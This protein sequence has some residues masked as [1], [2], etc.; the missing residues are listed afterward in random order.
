MLTELTCSGQYGIIRPVVRNATLVL[1]IALLLAGLLSSPLVHVHFQPDHR[2][3]HRHH[4]G[5]YATTTVHAHW[6][7][8]EAGSAPQD[9]SI[10]GESIG[11]SHGEPVDLFVLVLE[12]TPVPVALPDVAFSY[13]SPLRVVERLVAATAARARDPA[14]SVKSSRA[15]PASSFLISS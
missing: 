8:G 13:G 5:K 1:L 3:H 15:P 9:D 10:T 7:S 2:H 14:S 11:L 4:D 6:P 12:E